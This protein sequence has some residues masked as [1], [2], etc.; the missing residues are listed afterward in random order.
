MLLAVVVCTF[1]MEAPNTVMLIMTAWDK[2]FR[3]LSYPQF[4][5]LVNIL[6]LINGFFNLVICCSVSKKFRNNL[7]AVL[8]CRTR[9]GYVGVIELKV[10]S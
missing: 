4:G 2:N 7:K 3:L 5:G 9:L 1:T 6:A 8:F 10:T